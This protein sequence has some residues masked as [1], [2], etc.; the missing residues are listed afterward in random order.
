MTVFT[1]DW[2]GVV[3][4]MALEGPVYVRH[5]MLFMNV[6]TLDGRRLLHGPR[7]ASL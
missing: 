2:Y 5:I 1:L 6:L 7:W 3:C 4:Y